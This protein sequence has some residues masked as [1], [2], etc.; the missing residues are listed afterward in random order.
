MIECCDYYQQGSGYEF[1]V[2]DGMG[3]IVRTDLV[4]GERDTFYASQAIDI[5]E[6]SWV[7]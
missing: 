3:A 1:S 7:W 2:C 5:M 4:G 6:Y